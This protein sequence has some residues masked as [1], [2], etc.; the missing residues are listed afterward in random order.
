MKV[1]FVSNFLTHHQLPFCLEMV[2]KIGSDFKFV[3][4]IKITEERLKLGYKDM[5][6]DYDFVVRAYESQEE[7]D[8]TLKLVMESD[9]VMMGSTSDVYIQERLKQD[10]LVFRYRERIFPNGI[11]TWFNTEKRKNIIERHLKYRKNKNLYMLCASGY[12]ANDFYKLGVYKDKIYKWGYFPILKKY[13]IE[14]LISEKEKSEKINILW[15]SR[16]IKWKHPEY[17]VKL[18][19]KLLSENI[20]NFKIRMLGNGVE[21][22][23]IRNAIKE[24]GLEEYIEAI[25]AVSS[26]EV[27][28]YMEKAN[29]FL[30]TSDRREGW[31]AVLNESMN[32]GC[33]VV[34]NINIGSVPFLMKNNVNGLVYEN[35]NQFYTQVKKLIDDKE[36]RRKLSINAYKTIEETWNSKTATENLLELFDSVIN[37]KELEVESGPASRALPVRKGDIL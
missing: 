37:N 11:A 14:E 3:S 30:F 7:Y 15:T 32:S 29:I 13:N 36:L 16:F 17:M 5:D 24:K 28:K 27:R 22:E 26:D 18:A 1:V 4:T 35:F 8:R 20:N 34:A 2:S 9:V 19:E 6:H 10:K 25:G 31:G 12:G 21:L 33:A 23:N